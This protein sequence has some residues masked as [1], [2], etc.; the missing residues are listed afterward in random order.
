MVR[1]VPPFEVIALAHSETIV[2]ERVAGVPPE[3]EELLGDVGLAQPKNKAAAHKRGINPNHFLFII[4]PLSIDLSSKNFSYPGQ[5]SPSV[6]AI[7]M[8][9]KFDGFIQKNS[10]FIKIY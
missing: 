1:A 4:A 6:K 9:M 2:A 10:V 5:F 8:P 3:E 7:F